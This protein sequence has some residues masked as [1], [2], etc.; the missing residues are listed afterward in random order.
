VIEGDRV[1][2]TRY[3]RPIAAILGVDD[4]VDLMLGHADEYLR[5]RLE[6]CDELELGTALWGPE[7]DARLRHSE[8]SR[9]RHGR[10][11]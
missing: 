1:I 10:W 11:Y 8:Q 5:L 2:V 9:L 4:A 6:A 7:I 3:G